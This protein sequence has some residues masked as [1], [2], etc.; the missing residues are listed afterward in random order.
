MKKLL[1]IFSLSAFLMLFINFS[2][3]STD[4]IERSMWNNSICVS[5]DKKNNNRYT[6]NSDID[7]DGNNCAVACN[8][9]L[10]NNILESVWKCDGSFYYDGNSSERVKIYITMWNKADTIEAYYNFRNGSRWREIDN[11]SSSNNGSLRISASTT[12]PSV[13]SS[14]R[15]TIKTD[16][17]YDWRVS[18]YKVQYKSPSSSSRTTISSR[19]NSTYFSDY[20]DEWENGYYK[21]ESSDNGQKTISNF[22]KFAKKGYYKIFI[23]DEDDHDTSITFNVWVSSSSDD[24][25][26]IS[27]E[28]TNISTSQYVKLYLETDEDYEWKIEFSL[29]YK[30]N[31]SNSRSTISNLTNSTYVSDYSNTWEQGYY[32]MRYSD[33][34]EKTLSNLVKFKK[35]GYY[36][37][38]A[39][40]TYWE[41]DS[42]E[43]HV[44]SNWYDYDELEL[45]ADKTSPKVWSYIK[46]IINTDEDY[47]W[48]IYFDSVE[49]K[50]SSSSSRTTISSR[51]D[52]RYFS[53][54]SNARR[55][56]YYTMT[57]SDMGEATISN[58][59]KF[60]KT[61]YYRIYAEDKNWVD[62]YIQFNVSD[63]SSSN[64]DLDISTN[65]EN[66]ST[67]EYINLIIETDEDYAW[68]VYLTAKYKSSSSSTRS[69]IDNDSSSYF[70]NISSAWSDWY[71]T[72]T[73]SNNGYKKISNALKFKK[74]WYYKITATDKYDNSESIEFN[75]WWS[76]SST[77]RIRLETDDDTPAASRYVDL[78]VLAPTS[79]RWKINFSAKYKS[80]S[81]GTR[82][83]I[84]RTDS[85]YFLSYST[86]WR[87]WYINMT[88][89]DDWEKEISNIFKFAQ[90]WYYRIYAEDE[91]EEYSQTYIEFS[92]GN[93]ESSPLDW[94]TQK[95]YE[96]VVQ[97]YT[98]W[99]SLI[100]N[101]KSKYPW[102]KTNTTWKNRSDTLYNNMKDVKDK[103]DDREFQEYED[104]YDALNDWL[105]YTQRFI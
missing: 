84:S 34:G 39:E 62:D 98:I 75:V 19:T 71:V 94:Y 15:L 28:D 47:V 17:D 61:G 53:W 49:Y 86:T 102:L 26:E 2:S 87:N 21:M 70:S 56:G 97:I 95:E 5:I 79:F 50:S 48:K 93:P 69:S 20:S 66:P 32:T 103:K 3:A 25:I 104:F 82:R 18:F 38:T 22:L 64:E 44:T 36:Q 41:T 33:K 90:K 80:S 9:L 46:L 31:S 59:L 96:T 24:D 91:D 29:K 99:P 52:T 30:A 11:G 54:R 8:I 105:V 58:F 65:E 10:P 40:N 73:T 23:E 74:E 37:I 89:S 14:V 92:V 4:C 101:L 12:S 35:V 67:N 63:S 16:S 85:D 27:A 7:C 1:K 43:I 57:S 76:S 81:N 83:T 88:S 77:N 78:T 6:L 60:T 100:S 55:L 42:V 45:S 51:T 72:L 13:N 68:K